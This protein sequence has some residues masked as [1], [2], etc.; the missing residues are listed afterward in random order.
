MYQCLTTSSTEDL[1]AGN[2]DQPRGIDVILGGEEVDVMYLEASPL[3]HRKVK[4]L[5]HFII[6]LTAY[7]LTIIKNIHLLQE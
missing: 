7:I 3:L 5:K 6:I 4:H 2:G 1:R